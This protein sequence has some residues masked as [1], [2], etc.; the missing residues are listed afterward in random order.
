M[1]VHVE[2]NI[3]FWNLLALRHILGSWKFILRI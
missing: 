1:Y 2:V 3:Y